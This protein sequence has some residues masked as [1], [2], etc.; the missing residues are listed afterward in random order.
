M[1]IGFTEERQ[2]VSENQV[3]GVYDFL[4]YIDLATLRVSEREH[5]MSYRLLSSGT[6]TVVSFASFSATYFDARFGGLEGD[7]IEEMD[8][9]MPGQN[10]MRPLRTQI[11]NDLIPEDE[12]CFTIQV[13]PINISGLRELFIC[14]FVDMSTS[15]PTNYYCEHTICIKD[16]DGKIIHMHIQHNNSSYEQLIPYCIII[17]T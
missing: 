2:Y 15:P 12:E 6:A 5:R 11:V 3:P 17:C 13:S 7:P 14:D 10:M 16:D 4:V 1:V 9:L 8:Y